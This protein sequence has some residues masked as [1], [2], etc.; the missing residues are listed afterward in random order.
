MKNSILIIVLLIFS[1]ILFGQNGQILTV[2]ES[3]L[4]QGQEIDYFYHIF[5][6]PKLNYPDSAK[7]NCIQGKV[8]ASF[9][10][11][12]TGE[13]A[14]II[15]RKSVKGG[16]DQEVIR[17]IKLSSG[18]WTSGKFK[19][20]KINQLFTIP[21]YFSLL[22]NDCPDEIQILYQKSLDLVM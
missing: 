21:V 10:V 8:L 17:I 1:Q 15:I 13:I 7:Q 6:K 19:T 20:K 11:D 3:A 18:L 14:N 16:C 5:L 9:V 22:N 2:D 12:T 4:F